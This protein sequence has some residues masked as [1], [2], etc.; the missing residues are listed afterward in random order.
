ML[1]TDF[2]GNSPSLGFPLALI[3]KISMSTALFRTWMVYLNWWL[4]SMAINRCYKRPKCRFYICFPPSEINDYALKCERNI[5]LWTLIY[6]FEWILSINQM[7]VLTDVEFQPHHRKG[8]GYVLFHLPIHNQRQHCCSG[9][10]QLG[11]LSLYGVTDLILPCVIGR[12]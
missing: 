9:I 11:L 3:N 8:R 1:G 7:L 10:Q 5:C 12:K 4:S 6:K 2:F